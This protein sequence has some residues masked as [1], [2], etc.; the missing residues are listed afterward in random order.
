MQLELTVESF[1]TVKVGEDEIKAIDAAYEKLAERLLP[2]A[3]VAIAEAAVDQPEA[4]GNIVGFGVG[5]KYTKGRPTGRPAVIVL[6]RE[7]V[8]PDRLTQATMVPEAIDGVA[9]DV[10][11]TGEIVAYQFKSKHRPAPGGVSIGNCNQN[12]AG[13]LGCWVDSGKDVCILSNNH[14]LA[15]SN[16]S[17]AKA[18]ISQPGRLDGGVCPGD[19]IAT[20]KFFVPIDFSGGGNE[21]DAAIA[22]ATN[23]G[24]VESRILRTQTQLDKIQSPIVSPAIGLDVQKSGRTT[25][26]TKGTINLIATTV[27]VNY[28]TPT[29]PRIARFDNQF[30]VSAASGNFSERGDSGSLVTDM[31]NRPVGLLF[32]GGGGF[33]FCNEINRVLLAVSAGIHG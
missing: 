2:E 3:T 23:P 26:W 33:T 6:V 12:A 7:K 24:Y 18:S 21:V 31:D 20:L 9:T 5:E 30:R 22:T 8:D 14:V 4:P 28:G 27:N 11:E 25:G 16:D 29:A 19:A 32:A 13:T 10:E 1:G 17:P 15:M